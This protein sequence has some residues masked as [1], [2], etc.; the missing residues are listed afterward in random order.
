[1]SRYCWI[2]FVN[3]SQIDQI[4]GQAGLNDDQ[5]N[6]MRGLNDGLIDLIDV[7]RGLNG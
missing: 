3:D 7:Q 1:M 4:Y 6:G 2:D 5:M